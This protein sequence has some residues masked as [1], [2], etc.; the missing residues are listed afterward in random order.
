MVPLGFREI[1]YFKKCTW[2]R[3]VERDEVL[4]KGQRK[5]RL[6]HWRSKWLKGTEGS[7]EVCKI[8]WKALSI[9]A[10]YFDILTSPHT[11]W[12]STRGESSQNTLPVV[13]GEIACMIFVPLIILSF[14]WSSLRKQLNLYRGVWDMIHDDTISLENAGPLLQLVNWW[15]FMACFSW[16]Y[17]IF[18]WKMDG[19][20]QIHPRNLTWFTCIWSPQKRKFLLETII[21]RF[22]VKFR[23]CIH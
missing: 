21:F 15:V 19:N 14:H 5:T 20:H 13:L 9:Q 17:Q 6:V 18:I 8:L 22:H 1:I 4:Q 3:L 12:W 23:G 11:K 16:M 10:A 7:N 2:V